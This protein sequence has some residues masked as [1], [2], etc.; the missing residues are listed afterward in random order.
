[1]NFCKFHGTVTVKV[2]FLEINIF[3]AILENLFVTRIAQRQASDFL[4]IERERER[5]REIVVV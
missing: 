2:F 3:S 1:M 4:L 5:E